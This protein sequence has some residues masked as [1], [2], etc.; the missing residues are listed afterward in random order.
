MNSLNLRT[1]L[2]QLHREM[3]D[4]VGVMRV[5]RVRNRKFRIPEWTRNDA[6]VQNLLL[7]TFP[8]LET[9]KR[10]REQA[11]WWAAIIT[12]HWRQGRDSGQIADLIFATESREVRKIFVD[13]VCD[14][15]KRISRAQKGLRTDGTGRKGRRPRGRPKGFS[16][17][18]I[19][20][21]VLA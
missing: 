6:E 8:K 20:A 5:H 15:I 11:A 13:R 1:A 21:P 2:R 10:Q 4:S 12:L 17:K 19:Q 18:L 7:R 16:P 9:D 14:T 3:D